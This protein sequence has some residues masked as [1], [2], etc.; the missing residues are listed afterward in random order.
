MRPQCEI[1]VTEVLPAIRAI[2]AKKLVEKHNFSQKEVADNLD[3][4]QAAVSQY[5]S[6]IRGDNELD[7]IFE[8]EKIKSKIERLSN[9][10]S[11]ESVDKS[12]INQKF[13]NICESVKKTGIIPE[14]NEESTEKPGK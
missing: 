2:L 7:E 12:Q 9:E 5:L 8:N 10:I 4:T 1:I 13:C 11:E 3:V 6:S 14:I